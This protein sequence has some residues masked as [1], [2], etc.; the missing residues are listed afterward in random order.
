MR[1]AGDPAQV[2]AV[3][4]T[5]N[6]LLDSGTQA[7][8]AR[9]ARLAVDRLTDDTADVDQGLLDRAIALYARACAAHPPDPVE[10]ADWVLTVSFD[11]PPVTVPLSGFARPLGDTGLEHIRS[12]VDA[13][14]ALSTPESATTGEQ[15]I[16]QRLAEEVAELTGDV[17]RLIAAWTKLLPDVDISLKIVR[18]LRAAGRHAEAIA[19]AARARGTDPSRIA[20]LLA[21]GHDDDAWTLTK[22]LPAGSAH[23]AAEIYRKHVDELIERR[24]A[25]NPAANYA[26]AAV[27][28]R[29]LRTLH[30]DAGTRDE[31]TAHLADIV[32]AHGRKTRL[33]D[34]IRKARIALPKTSRRSTPEV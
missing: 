24:D 16:A 1:R 33:M 14:L 30:R 32:A 4:D 29:R 2:E 21:A 31:F 6:R 22:Q 25:R 28:L 12:T 18:A 11:D 34:E 10:L 17:D 20:E 9:L 5:L 19:H 13:K 26:R 27:A 3:L 15:A 7:D 8:V 23:V